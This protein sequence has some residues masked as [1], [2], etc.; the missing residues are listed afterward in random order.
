MSPM[1]RKPTL[2]DSELLVPDLPEPD[3]S[4]I[5]HF[6]ELVASGR[7]VDILTNV[8]GLADARDPDATA[9]LNAVNP[10]SRREH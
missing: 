1:K 10:P 3:L 4:D 5:D 9:L 8:A 7:L 2:E 6:H